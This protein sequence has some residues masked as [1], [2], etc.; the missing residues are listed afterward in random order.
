M[1]GADLWQYPGIKG[2]VALTDILVIEARSDNMI[3]VACAALQSAL[4]KKL[5]ERRAL[6]RKQVFSTIRSK[7]AQTIRGE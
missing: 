5:Q 3:R 2:V 1:R 7:A 6:L 4:D